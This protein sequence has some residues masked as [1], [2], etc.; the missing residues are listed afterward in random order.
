MHNKEQQRHS[1]FYKR[2]AEVME[3]YQDIILFGPTDAKVELFNSIRTD[4][5]F[6]KT[7]IEVRQTDKMTGNQRQ[8][9]VR[10]YFSDPGG[11]H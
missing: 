2:I 6:A 3:N 5:R 9:F 8:A 4:Q 10:E 7:K 1:E 11:L